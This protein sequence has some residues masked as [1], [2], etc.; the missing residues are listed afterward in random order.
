MNKKGSYLLA[1]G[2]VLAIIAVMILVLLSTEKMAKSEAVLKIN[3]VN[4]FELMINTLVGTP[5]EGMVEF[6]YN[7]SRFNLILSSN[8]ISV[9]L[10][11]EESKQFEVRTFRLPTSYVAEG[12]VKQ[13]PHIC[14]EKKNKKILLREC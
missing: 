11:G 6:P 8:S 5:G 14:L 7:I 2:E 3:T 9:F 1:V 13:A 10:P 4:N 12:V